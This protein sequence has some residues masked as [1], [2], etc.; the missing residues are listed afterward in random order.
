MVVWVA[1][2]EDEDVED[3]EVVPVV[4]VDPA[5]GETL[6]SVP[7]SSPADVGTAVAAAALTRTGCAGSGAAA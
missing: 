6:G 7:L 1:R 4:V 2:S 3:D 5:T